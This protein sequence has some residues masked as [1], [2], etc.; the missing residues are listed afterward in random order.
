MKSPRKN[1][2]A[3]FTIGVTRAP[4]P[5]SLTT[6]FNQQYWDIVGPSITTEVR[7]F[8]Q[9]GMFP[10][11]WNHTNLCL[12]PKIEQSKTMKDFRPISLYNVIYKIISKI[13]V[14][15]LKPVLS[16][17]ISETQAAFIL[18]RFITD[19]VFIVH[20]VLRSLRV[21]KICS[22]SYT[23]VETD[24]SKAYNRIEW[25]FLVCYGKRF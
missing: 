14:Q 16:S 7:W 4:G 19:N 20:E 21:R 9:T 10:P 8:F 3:L 11:T 24:I 2:K 1:K 5:D 13:V 18:G 15:K 6:S 12:I 25:K 17:I 22:N 23:V